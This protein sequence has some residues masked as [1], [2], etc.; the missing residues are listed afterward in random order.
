V[1][2]VLFNLKIYPS[3]KLEKYTKMPAVTVFW[4]LAFRSVLLFLWGNS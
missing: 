3:G 2:F 1:Y 4:L